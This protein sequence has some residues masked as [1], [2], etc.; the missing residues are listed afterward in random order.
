MI[1]N[2]LHDVTQKKKKE[3]KE[4]K[5]NKDASTFFLPLEFASNDF[6]KVEDV[7]A[8]LIELLQAT[9]VCLGFL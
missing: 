8:E 4:K 7:A 3:E 2:K 9:L 5:N 1:P 6:L